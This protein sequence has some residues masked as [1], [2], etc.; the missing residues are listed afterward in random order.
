MVAIGA[1]TVVGSQ[2][3]NPNSVPQVLAQDDDDK[4]DNAPRS[5]E[6]CLHGPIF[7]Y[8]A[9]LSELEFGTS[10]RCTAT[11][12]LFIRADAYLFRWTDD[13]DDWASVH[14]ASKVCFVSNNCTAETEIDN[15]VHG[16][17]QLQY[18]FRAFSITSS[19]PYSCLYA[20]Y[21]IP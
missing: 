5:H 9:A 18:C 12:M 2:L 11:G 3:A 7:D 10:V 8:S 19:W 20:E 13:D 14:S 1:A 15:P 17:Y 16:D 6:G 4:T 21:E